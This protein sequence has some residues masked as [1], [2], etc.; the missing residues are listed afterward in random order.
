MVGVHHSFFKLLRDDVPHV[1]LLR[2][3][4]YSAALVASNAFLA[5][6]RPPED[7]IRNIYIQLHIGKFKKMQAIARNTRIFSCFRNQNFEIL[8][9]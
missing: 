1:T 5:L 9:N 4:C 3:I 8:V 2:C 7:L 6:P